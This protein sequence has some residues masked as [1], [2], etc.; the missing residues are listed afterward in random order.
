MN[1]F[2][3]RVLGRCRVQPQPVARSLTHRPCMRYNRYKTYS[4]RHISFSMHFDSSL[5][6]CEGGL[7]MGELSVKC[8]LYADNRVTIMLLTHEVQ[9]MVT[10]MND[11]VKKGYMKINVRKIKVMMFERSKSM[12]E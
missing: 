9:T 6:Q 12:V 1:L 2:P 4:I 10:K 5:H 8:I 3:G 7:R 11:S